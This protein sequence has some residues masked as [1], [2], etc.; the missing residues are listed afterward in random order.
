MLSDHLLYPDEGAKDITDFQVSVELIM[1]DLLK[2]EDT[3]TDK[4]IT[5]DDSGPKVGAFVA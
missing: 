3:D 4:L 5:I 2:N 1:I